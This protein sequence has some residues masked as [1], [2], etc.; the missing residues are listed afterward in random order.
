MKSTILALILLATSVT[1]AADGDSTATITKKELFWKVECRPEKG[2]RRSIPGFSVLRRVSPFEAVSGSIT[3]AVVIK[4]EIVELEGTAKGSTC[5]KNKDTGLYAWVDTSLKNYPNIHV[6]INSKFNKYLDV[7]I[8]E[9]GTF[10]LKGDVSVDKFF[11]SSNAEK[12]KNGESL[13]DLK[14][15]L[16]FQIML[17]DSGYMPQLSS[18]FTEYTYNLDASEKGTDAISFQLQK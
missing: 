18:A 13:K 5:E 8:A 4:G 15:S 17:Q 9:D 3:K 6:M 12:I 7:K 14:M 1:F 10:K 16:V 2:I 11:G